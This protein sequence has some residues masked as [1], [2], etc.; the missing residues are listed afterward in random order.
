MFLKEKSRLG[1]PGAQIKVVCSAGVLTYAGRA[2]QR[3][4]E[5]AYTPGSGKGMFKGPRAQED[6]VKPGIVFRDWS[7][8]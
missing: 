6:M 8:S 5:G 1:L 3:K 7:M 2:R 4:E